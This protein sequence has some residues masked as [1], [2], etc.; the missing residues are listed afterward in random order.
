MTALTD[1][2]NVRRIPDTKAEAVATVRFHD[3][4]EQVHYWPSPSRWPTIHL[5]CKANL[6][7]L[8]DLSMD[9]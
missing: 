1:G 4:G 9:V 8:T 2:L 5:Q 7:Y 6:N 3:V